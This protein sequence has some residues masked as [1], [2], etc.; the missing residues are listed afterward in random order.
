MYTTQTIGDG[1][2]LVVTWIRFNA[3]FSVMLSFGFMVMSA[4]IV[5]VL[6]FF[7]TMVS[8]LLGRTSLK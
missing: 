5:L 8:N 2:R 1:L 7:S 6:S 3:Y 4:F